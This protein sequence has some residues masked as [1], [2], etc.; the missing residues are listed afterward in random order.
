MARHDYLPFGEEIPSGYA[1]RGAEWA[2]DDS[3][4]QKF[5]GQ[6]RDQE[7]GLDYFGARYYGSALGRWTSPDRVNLTED[8]LVSPSNTL[9]KYIYGGNNPLKFVDPDGEDITL[10]YTNGGPGGHAMLLAYDQS[11]GNSAVQSFGPADHSNMTELKMAVGIPVPGTANYG[12]ADIKSADQLRQEYS[13]VTIQTS[14]EETEKAIQYIKNH[15]DGNYDT[16]TN[17]CTTTCARIL[18]LLNLHAWGEFIPRSLFDNV[19]DQYSHTAPKTNMPWVEQHGRDYG[20]PRSGYDAFQLLYLSI[21]QQQQA[22]KKPKEVVKSK[23][24]YNDDDE[25]QNCS[26]GN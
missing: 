24:C 19:V 16:Y 4:K 21:Q 12:F 10:F 18:R 3:V 2:A 17:N 6:E 5:T 23:I 14:P 26:S 8:R 11:N 20:N 22:A 1:N 13:S 15:S 25:K 9:N 7:S